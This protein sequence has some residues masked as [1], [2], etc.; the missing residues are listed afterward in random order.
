MSEDQEDQ[1]DPEGFLKYNFS[2]KTFKFQALMNMSE[3]REGFF[4]IFKII[5]L[6]FKTFI[7]QTL[8]SALRGSHR[9]DLIAHQ[10]IKLLVEKY[11]MFLQSTIGNILFWIYIYRS[12]QLI[13]L[14]VEEHKRLLQS[15]PSVSR[16]VQQQLLVKPRGLFSTENLKMHFNLTRFLASKKCH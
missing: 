5:F 9:I 12:H 13:K 16:V 6:P 4:K 14:W 11:K 8:M 15:T 7:F 10:L 1:E 2:L 3:D